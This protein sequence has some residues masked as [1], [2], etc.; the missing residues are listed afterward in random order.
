[1]P[2]LPPWADTDE[3][4]IWAPD[5]SEHNGTYYMY[6]AGQQ[7][8][9]T[10]TFCIGVATSSSPLGPFN[11]DFPPITCGEV[12]LSNSIDSKVI[13][14]PE[15]GAIWLLWGSGL[16]I[17][18]QQMAPSR[19]APMPGTAS[20]VAWA[21]DPLLPY[22]LIMEGAW[23]QPMPPGVPGGG[24]LLTT[25]GWNCC[26]SLAAYAL[27]AARAPTVV[28]PWT[29]IGTF[30]PNRSSN[31]VLALNDNVTPTSGFTAP[32]HNSLILD[33]A[34]ALWCV[35]HAMQG[36]PP[37]INGSRVLMLDRVYL[38]ANGWPYF[39]GGQPSTTPQAAPTINVTLLAPG[40]I[41]AAPATA[42]A[43]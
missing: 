19:V 22:E 13:D 36:P 34:G 15:S 17:H 32:G 38:D 37:G 29:G 1:M 24:Y 33:D 20:A 11:A 4:N 41:R 25:S 31:V 2:L 9:Q 42:A 14:E 35:Y 28:G 27:F 23:V 3:I 10:Y 30:Y 16:V 21:P 7:A 12:D 6:F 43:R 8:N 40:S 18:V 39:Q 26:G 5:V